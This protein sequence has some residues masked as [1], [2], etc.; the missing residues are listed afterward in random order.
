VGLVGGL[1]WTGAALGDHSVI[2]GFYLLFFWTRFGDALVEVFF[3]GWVFGR[4][5]DIWFTVLLTHFA[6]DLRHFGGFGGFLDVPL[7][8]SGRGGICLDW[9]KYGLHHSAT[10]RV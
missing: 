5:G 2:I 7:W 1:D 10:K 8:G 6:G 4:F 3:L 9:F